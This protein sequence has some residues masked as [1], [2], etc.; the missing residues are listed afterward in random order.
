[1]KR[2]LFSITLLILPLVIWAQED[3]AEEHEEQPRVSFYDRLSNN[4]YVP[5]TDCTDDPYDQNP[6]STLPLPVSGNPLWI[7][8]RAY[9]GL[10]G[11]CTIVVENADEDQQELNTVELPD[12]TFKE[13]TTTITIPMFLPTVE[14]G[15]ENIR[16]RFQWREKRAKRKKK[17]RREKSRESDVEQCGWINIKGTYPSN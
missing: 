14:D 12:C 13:A 9:D 11:D 1:M 6:T 15:I 8:Y 3:S 10:E 4:P 2:L 17:N 7:Q 5:F 16:V